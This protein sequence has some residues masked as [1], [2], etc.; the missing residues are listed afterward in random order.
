MTTKQPVK[1]TTPP[2]IAADVLSQ[3]VQ[4]QAR[5]L[6]LRARELDLQ[7]QADQH[8]FEFSKIALDAQAKDRSEERKHKTA[9]KRSGY[10]FAFSIAAVL[11]VVVMYALYQDKN[12][13]AL[14]II[15]A[16]T[17][18][19]SGGAGGYALGVVRS[20]NN[21]QPEAKDKE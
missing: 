11:A 12:D 20:K 16:V 6:D 21:E 1:Q 2:P 14:E 19:V 7:R 17:F 4:N 5:E 18:V 15:K 8:N 9:T 3:F 10:V 13:F